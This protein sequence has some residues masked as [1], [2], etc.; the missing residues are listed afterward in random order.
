MLIAPSPRGSNETANDSYPT[1]YA[2]QMV[3]SP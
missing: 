2:T 1:T 3:Y